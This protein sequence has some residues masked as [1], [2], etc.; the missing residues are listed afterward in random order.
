MYDDYD[1]D[2]L[3]WPST[4]VYDRIGISLHGM[5]T[6]DDPEWPE[7]AISVIALA[8]V[9]LAGV[10]ATRLPGAFAYAAGCHVLPRIA[11]FA[12][13]AVAVAVCVP[14][15]LLCALVLLAFVMSDPIGT[16]CL[17]F[18]KAGHLVRDRV[19][20][21][22]ER[23]SG[24][25]AHGDW[26]DLFVNDGETNGFVSF[27]VDDVIS[28]NVCVAP[29]DRA[30]VRLSRRSW[31]YARTVTFLLPGEQFESLQCCLEAL[32]EGCRVDDVV[33][34]FPVSQDDARMP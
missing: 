34:C 26:L 14:V 33:S 1:D 32:R 10:G 25:R 20:I 2:W 8:V 13:L 28:G 9:V 30:A 24:I 12:L 6:Y 4:H 3:F 22:I 11:L 23:V 27:S 7:L 15:S 18:V 21:P 19:G 29:S 17:P 5:L 16:L 31:G